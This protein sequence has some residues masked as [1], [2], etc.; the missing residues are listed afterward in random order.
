MNRR[1]KNKEEEEN[2]SYPKRS[3][4]DMQPEIEDVK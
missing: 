3:R 2:A 4:Q 1:R